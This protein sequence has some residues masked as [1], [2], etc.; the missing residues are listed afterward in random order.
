MALA[1]ANRYA[2]AL[3]DVLQRT[4]QAESS[5]AV[6]AQLR[7]FA[8]ALS[9]SA[10]LRNALASPSVSGA[11][12]RAII[13]AICQ[14]LNAIKPVRNLLYLLSDRRRSALAG[15]VA[16]AFGAR[17]DERRGIARVEVTS[18]AKLGERE[19]EL[20]LDKFQRL[21]GKRTEATYAI[22]ESLLGG[23]VVRVGGQV[24][25][26][27]IAAQLRALGRTMAGGR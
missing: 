22:D 3:D 9:G 6:L 7:A 25:D 15:E 18:A 2:T 14:R 19:Q 5:D 26:G 20:L 12:K 1:I 13:E 27:S 17:L 23:A 10:E 16:E 11:D 21:T 8:E 24:F 4:G